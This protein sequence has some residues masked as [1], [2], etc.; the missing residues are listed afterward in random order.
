MSLRQDFPG[1]HGARSIK[2]QNGRD[3]VMV[4][5]QVFDSAPTDEVAGRTESLGRRVG[6]DIWHLSHTLAHWHLSQP[7]HGS[8][9]AEPHVPLTLSRRLAKF[10]GRGRGRWAGNTLRNFGEWRS[11]RSSR[12]QPSCSTGKASAWSA[13]GTECIGA[14][15]WPAWP[16]ASPGARRLT[17]TSGCPVIIETQWLSQLVVVWPRFSRTTAIQRR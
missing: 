13:A 4:R 15:R 3:H 11:S 17:S 1:R 7:Q 6:K 10:G 12:P 9:R 14:P 2:G 8:C 16:T 5:Q